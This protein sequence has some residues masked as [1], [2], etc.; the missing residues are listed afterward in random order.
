MFT[1]TKKINCEKQEKKVQYTMDVQM[2]WDWRRLQ[3]SEPW[4]MEK[5]LHIKMFAK[6]I[7]KEGWYEM[8]LIQISSNYPYNFKWQYPI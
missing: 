3:G 2:K 1:E 8:Y 5:F 7:P 6:L 4:K